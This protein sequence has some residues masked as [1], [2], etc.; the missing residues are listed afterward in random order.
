MTKEIESSII[1]LDEKIRF[2][3]CINDGSIRILKH[4][5]KDMIVELEEHKFIKFA[6]KHNKDIYCYGCYDDECDYDYLLRMPLYSLTNKMIKELIKKKYNLT[7]RLNT[8]KTDNIPSSPSSPSNPLKGKRFVELTDPR[9]C[10]CEIK[11]RNNCYLDC[12]CECLEHPEKDS[13]N[14]IDVGLMMSWTGNDRMHAKQLYKSSPLKGKRFV[15]LE[16][17]RACQC[18]IKCR[19]NCYMD[20][21]CECLEHPEKESTNNID[22]GQMMSWTGNDRMHAKQLYKSSPLKGKRFVSLEDPRACQCEIKC[23][24]NCYMDCDCE[25][26]EHPEKESTNNI[27]VGQMM[28]LTGNDRIYARQLYNSSFYRFNWSEFE[29][30]FNRSEFNIRFLLDDKTLPPRLSYCDSEIKKI[31][32]NEI[33]HS[34]N[35]IEKIKSVP[36]HFD[37]MLTLYI[38]E[39]IRIAG[40]NSGNILG[41]INANVFSGSNTYLISCSVEVEDYEVDFIMAIDDQQYLVVGNENAHPFIETNKFLYINS[42]GSGPH[43][44]PAEITFKNLFA[45]FSELYTSFMNNNYH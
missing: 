11:C 8:L 5:K 42:N 16:D 34:T 27:D 31:S 12:D 1:K 17:P 23:R 29:V 9:A 26:L 41:D 20:C 7:S 21:D 28:L 40:F 44:L 19:N 43:I 14:N 25:C 18:E 37:K 3:S 6:N 2:I 38:I 45:N 15:S 4:T 39:Q 36:L 24:N 32:D 33:D 13:N 10:Q 22:V 35:I 30:I